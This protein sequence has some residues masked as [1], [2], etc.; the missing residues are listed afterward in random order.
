MTPQTAGMLSRK[1]ARVLK[2]ALLLAA[3]G[4]VGAGC[5]CP[6][7]VR[8]KVA[9]NDNA[10]A[11][12]A[13]QG[14]GTPLED[15]DC[16]MA[17]PP[18][19][20]SCWV[21]LDS[22]GN[23]EVNCAYP[24]PPMACLPVEGRRPQGLEAFFPRAQDAQEYWRKALTMEAASVE[25]FI[26]LARELEFHGAPPSLVRAARRAARDEQRHAAW[27]LSHLPAGTTPTVTAPPGAHQPLRP[28]L[29]VALENVREGCV[30]ETFSAVVSGAQAQRGP[31]ELQDGL[32]R[33]AA[34]EHQHACLAWR[35]H[36]WAMEHLDET[37][38]AAVTAEMARG[39]ADL[40]AGLQG[41]VPGD[42]QA[43]GMPDASLLHTL[44]HALDAQLW[45]QTA[46]AT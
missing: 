19:V 29:D 25:S 22:D 28:L 11:T 38:R 5:G 18:G 36:A 13:Q 8:V 6:T 32:A 37:Q 4:A 24:G 16:M 45:S 21:G 44:A 14:A 23:A 34:E 15:G 9:A 41:V 3:P 30:H 1:V 20:V 40:W 33:L 17:C 42:I 43:L 35:V 46:A 7:E 10:K 12:L 39:S 27:C 2:G 26:R 31:V